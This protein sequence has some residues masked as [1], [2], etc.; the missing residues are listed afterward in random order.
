KTQLVPREIH[1][2]G[3]IRRDVP[4]IYELKKLDPCQEKSTMAEAQGE[5]CP[6]HISWKNSTDAK[7]N[8][9]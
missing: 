5:L 8:L 4:E 2:G 1:Y 3:S 7:I 9:P 6:R